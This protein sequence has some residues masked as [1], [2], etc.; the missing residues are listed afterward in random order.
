[1]ARVRVVIVVSSAHQWEEHS[2]QS[3]SLA[4]GS[5]RPQGSLIL[6][7]HKGEV[8][9]VAIC[10]DNRWLVTGGELESRGFGVA[11]RRNFTGSPR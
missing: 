4:I 2:K 11:V 5:L 6:Q 7:G 10:A 1:V 9:A 3:R 8:R